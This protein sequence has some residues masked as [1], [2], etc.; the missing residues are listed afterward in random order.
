MSGSSP[1][2]SLRQSSGDGYT[3]R[4]FLWLDQIKRDRR[5]S[6]LGFRVA[7]AISGYIN[8]TSGEAWPSRKTLAADVGA[9]PRAIWTAVNKLK[10][11]RYLE[12]VAN[13][14]PGRTSLFRMI[15]RNEYVQQRVIDTGQAPNTR[16]LVPE[17]SSE[18]QCQAGAT[19]RGT[20][21]ASG[22]KRI[23]AV[24]GTMVP[25]EHY[26]EQL[27]ETRQGASRKSGFSSSAVQP[28]GALSAAAGILRALRDE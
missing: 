12:V 6:H 15:T 1:E 16:T 18:L 9:S 10:A 8:R 13:R 28:A 2:P 22:R 20:P 23:A 4:K 19:F 5:I 21:T 3:R 25:P 26:K 7:Y 27:S 14:G 24:T 11:C 17:N